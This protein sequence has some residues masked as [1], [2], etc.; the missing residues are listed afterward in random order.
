MIVLGEK[1]LFELILRKYEAAGSPQGFFIMSFDN[2]SKDD[3]HLILA[4]KD[5][6]MNK[7]LRREC[8]EFLLV[9]ETSWDKLKAHGYQHKQGFVTNGAWLPD[10]VRLKYVDLEHGNEDKK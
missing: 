7:N 8:S 9:P 10:R 4:W 1:D 2:I 6:W 3:K 5:I